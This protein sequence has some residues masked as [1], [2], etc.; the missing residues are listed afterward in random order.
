MTWRSSPKPDGGRRR[1]PLSWIAARR[2]PLWQYLSGW[3]KRR[4]VK[5][6]RRDQ[7]APST[8]PRPEQRWLYSIDLTG[9]IFHEP[10][11]IDSFGQ[12]NRSMRMN[13]PAGDGSQLD[14]LSLPGESFWM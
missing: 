8:A 2:Q 10:S 12:Y 5:A 11:S 9:G 3:P 14:S 1:L 7:G 4:L 6:V 13:L